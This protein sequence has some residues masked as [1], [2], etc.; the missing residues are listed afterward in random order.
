MIVSDLLDISYESIED[1]V[2]NLQQDEM[3]VTDNNETFYC[4]KSEIY[5]E[6]LHSLGFEIIQ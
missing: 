2:E 4:V 3:V 6:K 1:A 5:F